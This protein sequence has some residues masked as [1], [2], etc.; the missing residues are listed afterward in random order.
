M[1]DTVNVNPE[2]AEKMSSKADKA[3]TEIRDRV[4]RVANAAAGS[5]LR[6]D[7]L[8]PYLPADIIGGSVPHVLGMEDEAVWNAASQAC[9]TEKVHY[10]YTIDNKRCWYLAAP[11]TTF[12][13]NPD[14]WCPLAAALPGNSEYWDKE[15]VY[16][17]EQEGVASALRWDP[18][19]H[20][21]QVFIG[22]ARTILPRI[23]SMDANFVTISGE[24]AKVVPW[25]QRALRSEQ[26]SRVV[27]WSIM[28]SGIIAAAIAIIFILAINLITI[29]YQ[30]NLN[31]AQKNATNATVELM[32]LATQTLQNE[33]LKHMIRIQE[34]LDV[35]ADNDGTL[36]KYEVTEQ[37]KKVIWEALVPQAF[38]AGGVPALAGARPLPG[39]AADGRV[40]IQG[41]K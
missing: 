27:T 33:S 16:I 36:T 29:T 23:Q 4:G 30:P 5:G 18:E 14:S 38:S 26:L 28:A 7:N 31:K 35:L 25:Q 17:Y 3:F 12:A 13:T 19:T 22:P 41:G 1:T 32:S 20:R 21:M 39:I 2:Q 8:A 40:T 24:V 9:G 10:C 15:T 6:V 11:S 37:G 34:L